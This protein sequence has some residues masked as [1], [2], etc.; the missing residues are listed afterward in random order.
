MMK[1]HIIPFFLS[2]ILV[3]GMSV[4]ASAN[5][6]ELVPYASNYL[7]RYYVALGAHGN[8]KMTISI[9]VD[10][11][12]KQDKIGVLSIDIEK[13]VNGEWQYHDTL[14]S[15]DHPEFFTYNSYDHVGAVDFYGT[16]GV[17]YRVT[18]L[19]YTKKGSGSDTDTITSPAVACK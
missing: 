14:D 1:K 17:T 8:G 10:G 12:G 6:N 19:V 2:L 7:E 11:V 3:F 18:L 5:D 16:P 13:K 9:S 4:P 15:I